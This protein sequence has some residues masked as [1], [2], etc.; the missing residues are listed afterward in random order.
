MP[1]PQVAQPLHQDVLA[2]HVGQPGD[3]LA[4][5]DGLL[6]RLGEAG[7]DQQSE[8]GVR[9][10]VVGIGVAVAVHGHGVAPALGADHSARVHAEGAHLILEM[11][12]RVEQLGLVELVGDDVGDHRRHFHPHADV[13]GVAHQRDAQP[14]G[15]LGEPGGALPPRSRDDHRAL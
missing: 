8:V 4:V 15:L 2:Q 14:P 10:L 3:R 1:G 7:G 11:A 5:L 9:G 12:R 6:E 13:H